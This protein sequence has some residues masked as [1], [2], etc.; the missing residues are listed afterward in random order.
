MFWKGAL[1]ALSQEGPAKYISFALRYLHTLVEFHPGSLQVQLPA[2]HPLKHFLYDL[3]VTELF[4][5]K[6]E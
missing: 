3:L 6:T 4:F 1:A 2:S 5:K